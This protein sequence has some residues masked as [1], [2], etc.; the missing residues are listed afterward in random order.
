MERIEKTI[1]ALQK[2]NIEGLYAATAEDAVR[3]VKEML[4]NNCI[5]TS[6]GSVSLAESGV[7]ELIKGKDYNY[8]D[9]NRMG[10]TA[11]E[12]L[13]VYKATI[14]CDFYFCSSNA[15]TENGELIN[16]DGNCNRISA[17]AFGPK[18]VVMIVGVNKIVK[19]I[20]EGFLRVKKVAAPKNCVRLGVDT[21]C[22][23]LGHCISLEKMSN[24]DISDGCDN[25]GRIC[26][27]YLVSGKQRVNGRITVIICGENLGY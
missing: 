5:I 15:V 16:V 18:K 8:Y 25:K 10:I 14:G 3:L 22:S 2:N 1:K 23:R 4:F 27:N 24:P 11:E 20:K 17:I 19:D 6:G 7:L 13:E 21:P 9:R 26:A 12:Q